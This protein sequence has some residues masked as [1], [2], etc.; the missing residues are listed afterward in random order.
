MKPQQPL[1][2][3]VPEPVVEEKPVQKETPKTAVEEK[4]KTVVEEKPVQE[5]KPKT[6]VEEK[7][8]TVVEQKPKKVEEAKP[9]KVVVEE[10]ASPVYYGIQISA[11]GKPVRKDAPFFKGYAPQELKVDRL[12]KYVVCTSS[13][14][15]EVRK[16]LPKVKADFKECFLVKIENGIPTRVR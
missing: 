13:S 1:P 8:K 15:E 9:E 16:N 3:P 2:E 12:Y 5:E 14:L 6:V 11:V 4:P 10:K 7:P